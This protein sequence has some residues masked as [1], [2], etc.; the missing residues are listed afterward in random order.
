MKKNGLHANNGAIAKRALIRE[1][2]STIGRRAAPHP[3]A[4]AKQSSAAPPAT[5]S[6]FHGE[7]GRAAGEAA[8]RRAIS[9]A[10]V[11]LESIG[12]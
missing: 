1:G 7:K 9:R 12:S 2:D 8:N 3:K 4:I 5:F 6:P 10:I 11:W